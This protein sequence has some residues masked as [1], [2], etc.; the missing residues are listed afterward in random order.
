MS[1]IN[2]FILTR[3]LGTALEY[4]SNPVTKIRDIKAKDK[5]IDTGRKDRNDW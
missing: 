3:D 2:S 5:L 4:K 1:T